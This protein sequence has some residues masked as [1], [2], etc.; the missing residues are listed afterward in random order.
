MTDPGLADA[1][2]IEPITPDYRCARSSRKKR[3]DALLPTM[4]GQTALNTAMKLD[5]NG[6]A[7]RSSTSRLIAANAR[8]HRE[9]RRPPDVQRGHGPRLA[10]KVRAAARWCTFAGRS[11][12]TRLK[13]GSACPAIIRPSFTLG[14]DRWRHRLQSPKSISKRLCRHR[15]WRHRRS[16]SKCWWKSLCSA[17]KSTRWKLSATARTTA[18]SSAPSKILI[19]WAFTPGTRSPLRPALTLTDKEYQDNAR[20]FDCMLARNWC[21]YRWLK[22]AVRHQPGRPVV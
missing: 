14:G 7:R 5:R 20:R 10:W 2:Y 1:T 17:G 3:P 21:G 15:R 6:R 13:F 9:S 12:R 4:G 16:K 18:S 11:A 19:P 22:R 8:R